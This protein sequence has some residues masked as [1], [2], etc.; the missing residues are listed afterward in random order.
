[1]RFV[2]YIVIHVSATRVTS[3]YSFKRLAIDHVARGFNGIGY[4]YYIR[5][6]GTIHKGRSINTVGAHVK[7]HNYDSV[8]I[9]CEG[10]LDANGKPSDTRTDAQKVALHNLMEDVFK[11]LFQY[12]DIND[13][14]VVG[15]RDF[16]RDK[17][18]NGIIDPYERLKECPCFHA[19]PEYSYF[20]GNNYLEQN[21]KE[22]V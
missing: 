9:C 10:G 1:V 16:S 11:E 13:I 18:R 2:R 19:I 4:H 8:G 17:N 12:Q 3:N 6:D 14:F 7:G 5:K 21:L 22:A 15:H 20:T